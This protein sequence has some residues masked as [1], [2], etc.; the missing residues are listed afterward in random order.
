VILGC[1]LAA[2]P[3]MLIG[4]VAGGNRTLLY[5]SPGY[6]ATF[7]CIV[8]IVGFALLLF[9]AWKKRRSSF[10]PGLL[11]GGSVAFLL[12]AACWGRSGFK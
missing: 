4:L 11:V 3:A 10:V 12:C 9:F 5:S 8:E 1:L 7:A 6:G 2:I